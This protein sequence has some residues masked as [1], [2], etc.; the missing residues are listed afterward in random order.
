VVE[1]QVPYRKAKRCK[2]GRRDIW[3]V[4]GGDLDLSL[5]KYWIYER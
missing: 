5:Y 2:A 3:I 1:V 4:P